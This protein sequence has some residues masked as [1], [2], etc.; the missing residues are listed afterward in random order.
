FKFLKRRAV[1]IYPNH[2]LALLLV[3]A[4][5]VVFIGFS[6]DV[7]WWANLGLIQSYFPTRDVFFAYN[8]QAWFL[9]SL[10]FCYALYPIAV[11]AS[12]KIKL[13]YQVAIVTI[14]FIAFGYLISQVDKPMQEW[15][16]VL[17]PVRFFDFFIGITLYR[18]YQRMSHTKQVM[19]FA[20]STAIEISVII[21]LVTVAIIDLNLPAIQKYD[22]FLMWWL[23][24]SI[25]IITSA[26]L[27]GN[28]GAI[29]KVLTSTPLQW[30]GKISLEIYL[31]QYVATYTFNYLIAPVMGHF[32][33]MAYDYYAI[34]AT[35][36]LIV[37]AWA[38]H[39]WVTIPLRRFAQN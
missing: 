10:M 23:P 2:W 11:R 33:F 26:M 12:R 21:I 16:Y 13:R 24:I 30:L 3:T 4:F 32:G 17:P 36:I 25:L 31:F 7:P 27:N 22:S 6:A 5:Y 37:L 35:P 34:F 38:I 28:E 18:V 14:A 1:L 39:K 19:T 29:G 15:I 8:G 20:K 9:C